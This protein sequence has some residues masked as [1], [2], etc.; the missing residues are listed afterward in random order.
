MLPPVFGDAA[1]TVDLADLDGTLAFSNLMTA[2]DGQLHDFR[3]S[4]LDYNIAV[5][6]N[7]FGDSDGVVNGSFYGPEQEEMAGVV[8]DRSSGVNLIAGFGGTR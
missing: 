2:V 7:G 8:D 5:T 6:G 3:R 4:R 1:M